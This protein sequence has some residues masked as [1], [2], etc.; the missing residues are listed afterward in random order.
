MVTFQKY[1]EQNVKVYEPKS[2]K[3]NST[4]MPM[5]LLKVQGL[6]EQKWKVQELK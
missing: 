3:I 2:T 4:K 6:N 5:N 1:H